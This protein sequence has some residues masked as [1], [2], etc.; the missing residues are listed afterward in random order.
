MPSCIQI[1]IGKAFYIEISQNPLTFACFRLQTPDS[2]GF[3]F[4]YSLVKGREEELG[5]PAM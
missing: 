5:V 1:E 3:Q 2:P 4:T